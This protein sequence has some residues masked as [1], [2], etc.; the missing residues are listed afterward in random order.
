MKALTPRAL[1]GL[2]VS[3]VGAIGFACLA[4]AAEEGDGLAAFDP[5]LTADFVARRTPSLTDVAQGISFVGNVPVLL[6]LTALVA[7]GLWIRTR[8]WQP[9]ALLA[10][11]MGGAGALTYILKVLIG[12]HRPGAGFVL[13][14]IDTGFSF[15]S[16][17]TL[18]ST[19]FFALLAAI[20]WSAEVRRTSKIAA[21][22]SAVV[23]SLAMGMSRIYLGYHWGTDVLAGWIVAVTWLCLLASVTQLKHG[24]DRGL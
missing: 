14:P 22:V 24:V 4:D 20:V 6:L 12:R 10:L 16:G 11:G 5:Q 3:V 21:V 13:G 17:H 9:P 2:V 18:S 23:L 15:P 1:L 19:V 8:R 7:L